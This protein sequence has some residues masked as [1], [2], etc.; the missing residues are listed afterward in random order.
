VRHPASRRGT[1]GAL[2]GAGLFGAGGAEARK[3]R[4]ARGRKGRVA[5]QAVN[6]ANLASGQDVSGCDY[7]GQDHSG[8][9]L[10]SAKMIKTVFRDAT[11]IETNLNSAN[12]KSATF[13]GAKLQ[14]ANLG[15]SVLEGA[16]LREA[17]LCGANLRSAVVRH[18]T[19]RDANLTRADLKR[20]TGCGSATFTPGTTF[21]GTRMCDGSIRNDDC[22]GGPA[23]GSCCT[24]SDCP[25]GESCEGGQC[26][27]RCGENGEP[28]GARSPGDTLRCCNGV[29]PTPTCLAMGAACGTLAQ[30]ESACCTHHA[31]CRGSGCV[32][33]ATFPPDPC[34]SDRDCSARVRGVQCVCS[35]CCLVT[36]AEKSP[37]QPCSICCSGRCDTELC[38]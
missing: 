27:R 14:R 4:G 7:S 24:D 1:L 30:C 35:R 37:Q 26:Q 13:R 36:G 21:C 18:A 25:A 12:M 31:D 8:E 29:C 5:A 6:C 28:C 3:K 10:S 20:A 34:A 33:A 16:S 19:F 22:P 11:L 9:N 23:A 2:L 17:D 38:L 15:S 32:C